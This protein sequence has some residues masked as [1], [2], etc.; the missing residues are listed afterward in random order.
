[1]WTE[2][3]KWNGKTADVVLSSCL[4]PAVDGQP[5]LLQVE[6]CDD[7][8]LPV[9]SSIEKLNT[10]MSHIKKKI[11]VLYYTIKQITDGREFLESVRK[12]GVRIMFDPRII[13]DHHT[14]WLEVIKEGEEWQLLDQESN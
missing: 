8:F 2:K 6:H 11:G 14:K 5:F 4:L 13:D 1:M 7:F 3:P 9:F 10:V 12:G